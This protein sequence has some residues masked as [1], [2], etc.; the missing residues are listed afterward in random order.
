MICILYLV[1][2]SWSDVSYRS[3][4]LNFEI[5]DLSFCVKMVERKRICFLESLLTIDYSKGFILTFH[6]WPSSGDLGV[7]FI[8][9]KCKLT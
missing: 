5:H 4:D 2:V 3:T 7:F 6:F 9:T 1:Q 8:L